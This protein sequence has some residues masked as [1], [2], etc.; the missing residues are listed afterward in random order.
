ML[1]VLNDYFSTAQ[2]EH[3][4]KKAKVATLKLCHISTYIYHII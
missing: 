1:E 4:E 2:E 3:K